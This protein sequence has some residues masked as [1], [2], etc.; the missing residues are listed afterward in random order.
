MASPSWVQGARAICA[1][2]LKIEARTR[3]AMSALALFAVVATV[4]VSFSVG[5][6]ALTPDIH[7]ALLWV[8]LFFA[9]MAGLARSFVA[10]ADTGTLLALRQ[11]AQPVHVF[12]GKCVYNVI[13]QWALTVLVICLFQI[14]L[15]LPVQSWGLLVLILGLG[16]LGLAAACTMVAAIVAQTSSRG[17]L[18]T[19]LAFPLLVPILVAGIAGTRK[20]FEAGDPG[21]GFTEV[22][23]LVAY[24]GVIV[25]VSLLVFDFLIK[26]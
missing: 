10:E 15:P 13:L 25:T 12:L 22:Q 17:T 6:F 24:A 23:M 14:L 21:A 1:K 11:S 26:E 8:V 3:S 2:D 4:A 5:T 9:A 20:A 7:A 19:V 16:G 18:F